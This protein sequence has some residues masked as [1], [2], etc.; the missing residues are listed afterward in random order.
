MKEKAA[1]YSI[2]AVGTALLVFLDRLSKIW[3]VQNLQ[4]KP[5]IELWPGVFELQYLENY[6]MAFGLLQNQQVFFYIMTGVILLIVL[7]LL[8]KTPLNKR[9]LPMF[10]VLIMMTGGAVGNLIDRATTK[11]VVDFLYVKLINFPIFNV[12]DS[13]VTLSS[14]TLFILLV[15]V[16]KDEE[17]SMV[18]G[19]KKKKAEESMKKEEEKAE[20]AEEQ[21]ADPENPAEEPNPEDGENNA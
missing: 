1:K 12:A 14:I 4:G 19:L 10:I 7:Y 5:A 6:G 13:F 21:P 18:Y 15:F 3:A 2:F 9:F 17:F 16:Y 20:E 11:Y 8:I